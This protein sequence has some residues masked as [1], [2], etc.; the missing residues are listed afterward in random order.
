MLR[1]VA[2]YFRPPV[3]TEDAGKSR[4]ARFINAIVLTNVPVL[5]VFLAVRVAAGTGLFSTPNLILVAL[6]LTLS[7]VW[8]LVKVGRVRLAGY[9]HVG[10]IWLATTVLALSGNGVRGSGFIGYFVVML[11]AGLILGWRAAA[12]ITGLSILSGFALA[13]AETR[14]FITLALGAATSVAIEITVLFIFC[15]V[16]LYLI[17]NSHEGALASATTYS[18][19]LEVVNKDLSGL[20]DA[21]EKRVAERTADLDAANRYHARRA[22]QFRAITEVSQA[23]TAGQNL[24]E[25]LPRIAEVI[26][27]KFGFYHVGI[28]LIDPNRQYAILSASNSAGGQRMLKRLHQLRVGEQGIVGF[29][30]QTGQ[31]RIAL[32]VGTDAAY[33]DNPDLPETRSELGLP[34]RASGNTL[35]VLDVQSTEERA[36]TDDDVA[37]LSTLADQV[38]LAIQNARLFEQTRRSLSE[39]EALYGQ[40]LQEAWSRLPRTGAAIGVRY[41][42]G[43][44]QPLQADE[45][46]SAKASGDGDHTAP[47]PVTSDKPTSVEVP[48]ILRGEQIGKLRIHVPGARRL[49]PDQMDM[50]RAVAERVALSAE[51]ARLFEETTR[52]AQRER[53]VTDIS[54][55]IRGTNDPQQMIRTAIEEL[56]EALGVTRVEVISPTE[57]TKT[58]I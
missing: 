51:N 34:L 49:K 17:I 12:G 57:T 54:T 24:Q 33:F 43:G 48:I 14:G 2:A 40:Y 15:L 13:F 19:E 35:G 5:L 29:V 26:S 4:S 44:I 10:M 36:F 47:P 16:F 18:R 55:K 11:M 8:A 56:R 6:I 37:V 1:S 42:A 50:V 52:R 46:A 22:T 7:V 3:F 53:L 58:D 21:L 25:L 20:R 38:S 41:T 45:L 30:A 23:I 31:P 39:A 32:D 27:E 9:L 28:F